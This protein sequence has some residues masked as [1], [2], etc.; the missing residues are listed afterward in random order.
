[1]V[2]TGTK[3]SPTSCDGCRESIIQEESIV[4]FSVLFGHMLSAVG[5]IPVQKLKCK[6]LAMVFPGIS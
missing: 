3:G 1:M 2:L 4:M 5:Y 6:R